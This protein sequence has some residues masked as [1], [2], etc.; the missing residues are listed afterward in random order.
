MLETAADGGG[1]L[2]KGEDVDGDLLAATR[3]RSRLFVLP[4][5]PRL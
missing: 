5:S 2:G 3:L 1:L 4:L